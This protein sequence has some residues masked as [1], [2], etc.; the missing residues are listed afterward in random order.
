MGNGVDLFVTFGHRLQRQSPLAHAEGA[1]A[2]HQFPCDCGG[3][4]RCC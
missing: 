3:G 1:D 4:G 2:D